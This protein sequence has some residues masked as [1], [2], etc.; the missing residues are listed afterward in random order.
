MYGFAS[1]RHRA[2]FDARAA[3]VADRDADH[4]AAIHRRSL[5]LVR[6]FEVRIEA[7]IGVHAGVQ[8][9]ADIV[10]VGQDAVHELPGELAHLLF[11][12][13]IPEQVLAVLA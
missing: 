6:R 4:R 8:Q 3:L 9:Q 5:D 1:G 13:G 10:A 7:A 12:L 2:D 11:A